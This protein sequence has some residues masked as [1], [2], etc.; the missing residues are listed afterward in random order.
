MLKNF[1]DFIANN[2]KIS[3]D[4]NY[5]YQVYTSFLQ[6]TTSSEIVRY[7]NSFSCTFQN[8][9]LDVIKKFCEENELIFLIKD[10]HKNKKSIFGSGRISFS[11][12]EEKNIN[13]QDIFSI[14]Y[15]LS[16]KENLFLFLHVNLQEE[17]I[18]FQVISK[19]EEKPIQDKIV[20]FLESFRKKDENRQQIYSLIQEKDGLVFSEIGDIHHSFLEENYITSIVK[21]FYF[22]QSELSKEFLQ[23]KFVLLSGP[24]GTGK[25][26]FV[27]AL[28]SA[29]PNVAIINFDQS[30]ASNFSSS[31]IL[32]SLLKFKQENNFS[33][34]L[35]LIEDADYLILSRSLDNMGALSS[36]LNAS[37]GILGDI[38]NIRIIA[39]TNAKRIDIEKALLRPGRLL[40]HVEFGLL[41]EEQANL[42][43][44]RLAKEKNLELQSEQKFTESQSLADI[45][46]KIY[47]MEIKK[48]SITC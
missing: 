11:Y 16:Y 1:R 13:I 12:E 46:Q 5:L 34:F 2:Y 43:L 39:T 22:L 48:E 41:S 32:S 25:T 31:Q 27:R 9:I 23:N 44:M 18:S 19:I 36:L 4:S 35:F 3:G 40:K 26:H 47:D 30:I 14:Q 33:S 10:F 17:T 38:F 29:L 8:N 28:I 6:S 37:D 21:T 45:Y 42:I 20:S 7:F 24:P 15:T